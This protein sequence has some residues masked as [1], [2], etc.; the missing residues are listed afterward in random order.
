MYGCQVP[1]VEIQNSCRWIVAGS[2]GLTIWQTGH[3]AIGSVHFVE[4]HRFIPSFFNW[5]IS[6]CLQH[7]KMWAEGDN[8]FNS[9]G[10]IQCFLIIACY[11]MQIINANCVGVQQGGIVH[12]CSSFKVHHAASD[13]C[14][15]VLTV[16][17]FAYVK[18]LM[19]PPFT[20]TVVSG[21]PDDEWGKVLM[22]RW[23]QQLQPMLCVLI[24]C[25]E[26]YQINARLF[27]CNMID[28]GLLLLMFFEVWIWIWV[29]VI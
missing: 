5:V 9:W 14:Q 27:F 21:T 13:H 1:L 20:L 25:D 23:F 24:N 3:F 7:F 26:T 10:R 17:L 11:N 15:C 29:F 8:R 22:S 6:V 4:R 28:F 19:T 16:L 2:A 12:L 18:K